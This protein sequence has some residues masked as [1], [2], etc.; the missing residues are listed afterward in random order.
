MQNIHISRYA[1]PIAVGFQGTVSPEDRSWIVFVANDGE[2]TLWRRTSPH[3]PNPP[4]T[5][6]TDTTYVDVELPTASTIKD[7]QFPQPVFEGRLGAGPLDFTLT[8]AKEPFGDALT[9]ADHQREAEAH[10]EARS[11]FY[12]TLNCRAISCW[13]ETEHEAIRGLLNTVAQLCTAGSLDH[14]GAP[15]TGSKRRYEAVYGKSPSS[16][17]PSVVPIP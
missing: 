16:P 2:A 9:P 5:G 10:P 14:T 12:A 3:L 4:S 11:G 13:G 7:G 1:D 8:P 6:D 15:M 17:E